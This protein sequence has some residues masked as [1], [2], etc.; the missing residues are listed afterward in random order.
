MGPPRRW[1]GLRAEPPLLRRMSL[2]LA[3]VPPVLPRMPSLHRVWPA[4]SERSG[5]W[6]QD[7]PIDPATTLPTERDGPTERLERIEPIEQIERT[8]QTGAE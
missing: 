5:R 4:R 6:Q 7:R 2:L 1:H 3:L 8:W